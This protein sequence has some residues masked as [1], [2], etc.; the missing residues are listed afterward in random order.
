MWK[1][2]KKQKKKKEPKR[3]PKKINLMVVSRRNAGAA[4]RGRGTEPATPSIL[5]HPFPPKGV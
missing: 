5:F 1:E 2:L 4:G 3:H